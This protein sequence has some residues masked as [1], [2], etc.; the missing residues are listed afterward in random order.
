[1]SGRQFLEWRQNFGGFEKM[2]AI[3]GSQSPIE[4]ARGRQP[5]SAPLVSPGFFDLLGVQPTVGRVFLPEEHQRGAAG[6]II[7]QYDFWQRR[8]GGRSDVIGET[9]QDRWQGPL[10]VVGVMPPDF[11]F[12]DREYD[13]F[14]P[15]TMDLD[16]GRSE[17]NS[18]AGTLRVLARLGSGVS[19]EQAQAEVDV[20]AAQL[21]SK[22]PE[23]EQGWRVELTPLADESAGEIRPAVVM[24]FVSIGLLMVVVCAN[25]GRTAVGARYPKGQRVRAA[26]CHRSGAVATRSPTVNRKPAAVRY[27]RLLRPRSRLPGCG[28]LPRGTAGSIRLGTVPRSR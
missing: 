21:D 15:M 5:V 20:F 10:T 16:N 2:A 25:I 13:A 4:D 1:M 8:F 14:K 18:G 23:V 11:V 22:R 24:L 7:L 6:R 3:V 17:R 12:F 28:L 9:L 19:L 27:G 26:Q